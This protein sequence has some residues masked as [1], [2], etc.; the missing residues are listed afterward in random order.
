MKYQISLQIL[1]LGNKAII[2]KYFE[3]IC[4]NK[5][6]NQDIMKK[7]LD[8]ISLLKLTLEEM[9]YLNNTVSFTEIEFII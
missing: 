4:A 3:Q 9:D 5:F 7:F 1:Y 6:D 8:K 2:K